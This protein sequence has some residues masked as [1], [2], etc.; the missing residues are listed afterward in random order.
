MLFTVAGD[1]SLDGGATL[2]FELLSENEY[3]KMD[4]EGTLHAGGTLLVRLAFGFQPSAGDNFDI[5]DFDV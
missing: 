3:S 2:E 1:L 4:V 5:L